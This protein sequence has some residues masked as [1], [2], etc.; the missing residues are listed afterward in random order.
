[1]NAITG[2]SEDMCPKAY[3]IENYSAEQILHFADEM[4]ALPRKIL[5]YRTPEKLFDAFLDHVY[6]VDKVQIA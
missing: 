3:P 4:N 2:S 5:E 1:M 6:S